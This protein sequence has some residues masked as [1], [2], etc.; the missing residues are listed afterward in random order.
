MERQGKRC[1]KTGALTGTYDQASP[2]N[3]HKISYTAP[4]RGIQDSD[5]WRAAHMKE[6]LQ[7]H[8]L[9]QMIVK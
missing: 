9:K 4:H 5:S 6:L 3:C 1:L 7:A 8:L 2:I